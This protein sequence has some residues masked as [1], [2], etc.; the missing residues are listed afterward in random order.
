MFKYLV[1]A[2]AI[3]MILSCGRN[4]PLADYVP[5]SVQEEGLKNTFLD[6]Q[7][8]VN[9]RDA[10]KIENLIHSDAALMVGRERKILSRA[11]YVKVL[12]E[13]LADNPP[14]ALSKPKI[15]VEGHK[16]EVRI[17]MT[18]GDYKGL[19]VYNMKMED[20]KWYIVDWKY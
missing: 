9:T 19:I 14:M 17:Y 3:T 10:K 18:R 8:G 11:Q 2:I 5:K 20:N 6:F 1:F 4:E 12:P 7:D 13:R 16:A 15:S